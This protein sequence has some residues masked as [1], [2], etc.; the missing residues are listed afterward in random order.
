[1]PNKTINNIRF[2][3]WEKA[4]LSLSFSRYCKRY[5][6]N[7]VWVK[8]LPLI[9]IL[10]SFTQLVK[11]QNI[12]SFEIPR[13]SVIEIKD[14][15]SDRIYPIFIKLPASYK[16][17]N[18]KSYPVIYLTDAWYSFQI[19]SGATRFPMN[20]GKMQEAIIV[21]I[22]YSKGSKGPSSR[23]RD[24]T[25]KKDTSWKLQ[26]GK[27]LE[28]AT[29]IEGS[30]FPYIKSHYRVNNS[31]TY[32][33]NSLGGLFGAYIF[34]T[35]PDMF[36]NYILGSPSVWFNNSDILKLKSQPNLNTHNI[37]IAVGARETIELDSPQHDMVNGAN[38]LASKLSGEQFPNV[39]V[40]LLTVEGANHETA[41]P[42]TAIQGLY[43]LFKKS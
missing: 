25:H 13:S 26:T 10:I 29:F 42:T 6:Q 8:F 34:L 1:M 18:E 24:Y 3:H 19:V 2:A 28:H 14:P 12:S 38:K 20:S 40:K 22:S 27:A 7:G 37:F 33:G 41:F 21:G 17:N 5:T 43:W 31:R 4:S 36:N 15:I 35:K 39:N 16:R 23:V 32:V 9:F 11:A 30:I